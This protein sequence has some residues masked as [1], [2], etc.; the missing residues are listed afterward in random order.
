VLLTQQLLEIK[1]LTRGQRC[2]CCA[3]DCKP[4]KHARFQTR[5][6]AMLSADIRCTQD[7]DVTGVIMQLLPMTAP[8]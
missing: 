6:C 2:C 5:D 1:T 7:A 4:N 3:T 8:F